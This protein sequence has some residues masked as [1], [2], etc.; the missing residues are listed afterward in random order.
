LE[1]LLGADGKRKM[2]LR[3]KTN[4]ELFL[5]Y[6][7]QLALRHRS[8]EALDEA[9]RLLRHFRKYLGEFPPSPELAT[10]F[11]A[12]F[13]EHAAT[14]LYRYHSIVKGFMEWYG[15]KLDSRI[16][17]PERLP[18]YVEAGEIEKLKEAMRSKQTHK[19]VIERNLLL[20]DLACKTGLRR[21]ELSNLLVRD[22]DLQRNYLVVRQ[23]KEMKDRIID[24][25]P[26]LQQSLSIY[27]KGKQ[28]DQHVF[29]LS[30]ST[31]SGIIRWAA[32][33]SGVNI[34]TH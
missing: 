6:D 33:K 7:S 15:E 21:Q 26:S 14:T 18:D 5:L 30:P 2:R 34:H 10:V 25:T 32:K 27:L 19:G 12:Q 17:V 13:S 8:H 20:I 31:I 16:R 4:S 24:L 1:V 23:G 29:N 22:V 9:K 28:P 11:L 3:R